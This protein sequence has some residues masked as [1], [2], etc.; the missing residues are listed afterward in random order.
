MD[1]LFVSSLLRQDRGEFGWEKSALAPD[2]TTQEK[3]ES[4]LEQVAAEGQGRQREL[5]GD[6]VQQTDGAGR[7]PHSGTSHLAEP[8]GL[9]SD[10]H[11]E[12]LFLPLSSKSFPSRGYPTSMVGTRRGEPCAEKAGL[13]ACILISKSA[14]NPQTLFKGNYVLIF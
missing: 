4:S 10:T 9:P 13:A 2:K 1:K 3:L 6:G 7:W 11:G 14:H 12:G 8:T 5:V